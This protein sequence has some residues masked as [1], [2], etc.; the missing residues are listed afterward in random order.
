MFPENL[1][2]SVRQCTFFGDSAKF[3]EY[4]TLSIS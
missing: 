2:L 3:P 1:T 4:L